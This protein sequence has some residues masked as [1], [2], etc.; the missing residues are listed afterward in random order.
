MTLMRRPNRQ[1]GLSPL[2]VLIALVVV[3]GLLVAALRW[4]TRPPRVS[5][6]GDPLIVYCA[7]GMFKPVEQLRKQYEAE[8]G[9]KVQIEPGGS[10]KLLSQIRA[11]DGKRGALF[12]AA[13]DWYTDEARRM[14]LVAEVLPAA[15]IH[16]VI[17]VQPGNPKNI[18]SLDDLLRDDVKLALANPEMAS[19]GK[20][21]QQ[22]LERDGTW[23]KIIAKKDGGSAE[24]SFVG[25]V[26]EVT[27]AISI[28]AADAGIVWDATAVQAKLQVVEAAALRARTNTVTLAVLAHQP[29]SQATAA[30]R[31]ARYVTSRDKGMPVFAEHQFTPIDDADEWAESP[32]IPI[33]AGAMLK[34]GIE[35][36]IRRFEQ[37]EGVRIKPV[38]NGCG[39]LVAQM[40][41][42]A[43]P[44]LYI[45]CDVSFMNDVSELFESATT[46]SRNR[47]VL[48]VPKGNPKG[49]AALEDLARPGLKVGLAHP[50]NSALGALTDRLLKSAGLHERVYHAG[51]QVVHSDA[52]H[53][54]VNMLRTGALDACV[55]YKSNALSAP[56]SG[57]FLDIVEIDLPQAIAVQPYAVSR[58]AAHKH[59]LRRL[60]DTI[61]EQTTADQFRSIGFEWAHE[62]R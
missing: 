7:A 43:R 13:D 31:F 46:L 9:V 49:I 42:G 1:P 41:A 36:A 28:G 57:E 48:V 8:Y 52:G 47:M 3:I 26:N 60:L 17:A 39:I 15:K 12:L 40:K 23:S 19:V 35:D 25:T 56:Q 33:M 24:V 2:S 45:S 16:P 21:V 22:L 58:T 37:R 34:P 53:M 59:L 44:E 20:T 14:G 62:R 38:Y 30:L 29:E 11:T 55:V 10:G 32:E 5:G 54:L 50:V 27:Q 61:T 4:T 6:G 51:H 18:A